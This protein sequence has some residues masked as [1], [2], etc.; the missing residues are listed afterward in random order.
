MTHDA[1]SNPPC[2]LAGPAPYQ[3]KWKVEH[4]YR[5]NPYRIEGKR[6]ITLQWIASKDGEVKIGSE[7]ALVRPVCGDDICG[8]DIVAGKDHLAGSAGGQIGPSLVLD[9]SFMENIIG[10]Q[11]PKKAAWLLDQTFEICLAHKTGPMHVFNERP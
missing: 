5:G 7:V 8:C 9:N 2:C 11:M 10:E 3:Y 1:R 4:C 6:Q